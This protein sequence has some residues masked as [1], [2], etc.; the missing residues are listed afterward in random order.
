MNF[1]KQGSDSKMDLFGRIVPHEILSVL[2]TDVLE[3]ANLVFRHHK[4]IGDDAYGPFSKNLQVSV[5]KSNVSA[6][7]EGM[8]FPI[9]DIAHDSH[10]SYGVCGTRPSCY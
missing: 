2:F 6:N 10:G 5:D 8:S 9:V 3:T 7:S 4:S 1:G